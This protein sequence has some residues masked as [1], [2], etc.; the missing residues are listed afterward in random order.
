MMYY[1]EYTK[2]DS[3]L[4]VYKNGL[5]YTL[6]I[7][8]KKYDTCVKNTYILQAVCHVSVMNDL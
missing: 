8:I 4:L 6:D 3:R 2:Q 5:S 1:T 7:Y